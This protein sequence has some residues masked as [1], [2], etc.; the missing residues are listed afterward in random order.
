MNSPKCDCDF[1]T[2][3]VGDGCSVCN[4]TYWPNSDGECLECGAPLDGT[5]DFADVCAACD[6]LWEDEEDEP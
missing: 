2:R 5:E 1:R 3:L 6:S 4:P